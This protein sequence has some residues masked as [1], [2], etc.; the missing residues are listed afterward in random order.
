MSSS[1]FA[2]QHEVFLSKAKQDIKLVE[3]V[4]DDPTIASE[5]KYFH[6]QQSVEKALKSLLSFK[7]IQFPKSHDLEDLIEL[8]EEGRVSLP[9]FVSIL[10]ELTPYAVEF[11]YALSFDHLHKPDYY[12]SYAQSMIGFVED[13][14][15]RGK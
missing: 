12:L 5:I 1:N 15:K 8:A 4:I 11:R 14:I 7:G 9:D 13:M 2:P 6:L 3:R 10:T